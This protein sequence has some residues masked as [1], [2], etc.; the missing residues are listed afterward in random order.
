MKNNK[1]LCLAILSLLLLIG[2]ASFAAKEK[3]YVL[4]SPDGTLKVE[5]SAGNELAY[6]VM[7]GNDTILSHSNIGLVLENGTIVGKTPRITGERRRKIKDNIESPFYRFKEFV[8]TGNELDLKLKGGFGIIFR[9]YNEGVAYRF[10]TTQSSDIIIK[11]EQAE[12]NFKE[13]YTAYLPYTTNDKKPMAMAYQ[14]VYDITPLSKAQP[15]LAFLPVTV[16]CGSVKLTL[17]ESDLEAYPGVFVQS[18]QGKYGLKG[19]FAPYPAKTDFYP[20]RKQEYVTETTDFISRSRGSRSYPWRVLAITEKDTDMPV[21]NLVYALASPNRIGDTSWIKTGKVAWDWWNDWNLKGVPFKAGI[22]MDTYKYYIDFASRNGLEFIVLDEGWYDPKSG[23]M[24][25]VIPELDLPELIAYGKSKGVE[26]VLWTVFNVLDSQ[27][28]AACKKYA[29]MGIKGF[30]V[31]FLDR[32]DQTAVEMVYRIAEMTARYKLTLDLHG[33]YKPTGINRTYPHIINFESVFGMEEVKWTDI[34]NNMPLYD[35]TFPYIRMMAGPVDYT[36]GAMRNATKADWRAMYYTPASMGTRCHQLAA[37]IVHDSPFT[38]LCDAPTNYLNE[39]ECVDFIA[40][41]PVEVDS[42]FIA[43]GELGKYIVT[44]RKKDV[45]WYIGGMTNWDERDVQLDFSFLP[46]GM[47]Y[48]AVLFKDGVNANK[49]AEDYRKET[50][51]IDKDSRLT[52]HLASGGGFAMKLEL[53]PVH[54]QVTGIPEGKNIPSFYQKYIETEGLYV[55]SSGKVS[56]EALLKACDIISLMLAKRPDVKAHM[57]KKG[58]HVM[59]IGKDEETCDLPEFAHI[60]NCE[61]SIKYWNWR[62]RGFGGAPEDEFSSSCGEENL[63]ALPQDKYV[64]ENILIHE[65]AHLIHTVGIVGVEPD[66]NERLEALRQN[67]IRKGL[68]EKTYAVSNKEEYFAECVQ[69]FFNCNRYAEP[70]NGVHNRVNRRTKLKTYDPDMYRLLQEYFYE[71][72]I[73]IHNVVHE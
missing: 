24:L 32:D 30:K 62:A 26:I 51:R 31:D 43:S 36:P 37:Y 71:I 12:F 17:L 6:Q 45:N 33:I 34:K 53:C 39:Q 20:W 5:I 47:S 67:A 23:D 18:Q 42:T 48:T 57:V 72:E 27:L 38:M 44:V 15:K 28:E 41:L 40:S 52:L 14:N 3:K 1:K 2:N 22:N 4:S 68:W 10:Y 65:F 55:T 29:D 69:S 35:V 21:N 11:E 73:P 59:I 7:H 50:I 49:Q 56:D 16:D 70:A 19:V 58:C 66:F 25:T 13:D 60:C 9:A 8:A 61:D 64:G 46:E 63:L 54:G